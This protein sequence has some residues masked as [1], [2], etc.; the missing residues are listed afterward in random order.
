MCSAARNTYVCINVISICNGKQTTPGTIRLAFRE[1]TSLCFPWLPLPV[2]VSYP[3]HYTVNNSLISPNH[4]TVE[5][6]HVH[7]SMTVQFTANNTTLITVSLTDRVRKFCCLKLYTFDNVILRSYLMAF[8]F[9]FAVALRP[10]AGHGLL[11]LEVSRSHTTTH[12]SR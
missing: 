8:T 4:I 5:R 11:I 2:A 6:R 12:H 3:V 9:F 10:N 1:R 7:S